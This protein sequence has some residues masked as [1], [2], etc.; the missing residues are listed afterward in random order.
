MGRKRRRATE[1]QQRLLRILGEYGF[2]GRWWGQAGQPANRLYLRRVSPQGQTLVDPVKV[3]LEFQDP[4]ELLGSVLVIVAQSTT[5]DSHAVDQQYAI[6][7]LYARA[8]FETK[9]IASLGE[10]TQ[11][12]RQ[13]RLL[14]IPIPS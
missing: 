4:G 11:Y 6:S 5:Q 13:C 8:V 9:S 7:K 3:Y 14:G 10:L 12:R 2:R 1:K